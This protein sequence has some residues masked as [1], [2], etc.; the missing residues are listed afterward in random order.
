DGRSPTCDPVVATYS[1]GAW[2][3]VSCRQLRNTQS[4]STHFAV[5]GNSSDTGM[6]LLPAGLNEYGEAYRL[7]NGARAMRGTPLAML[8]GTS[9]PL[10]LA[11]SG[12]GSQVST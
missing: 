8:S 9:L 2:M 7:R 10:S 6:P 3:G 5:S 11:S 1:A 12:L 4:S